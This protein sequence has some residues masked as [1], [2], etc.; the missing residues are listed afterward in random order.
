LRIIS[1]SILI[2]AIRIL[3]QDLLD[4]SIL[5]L[6][7]TSCIA[8]VSLM[9]QLVYLMLLTRLHQQSSHRPTRNRS[10]CKCLR[11]QFDTGCSVLFLHIPSYCRSYCRSYCPF[12]S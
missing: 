12:W 9:L 6:P 3:W 8:C 10:S 4:W 5:V 11:W 7:A 2:T 1:T